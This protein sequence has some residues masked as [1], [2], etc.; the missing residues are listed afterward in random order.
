MSEPLLTWGGCRFFVSLQEHFTGVF[1]VCAGLVF[2]VLLNFFFLLWKGKN[3]KTV[4]LLSKNF[5]YS[6]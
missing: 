2:L 3:K 1:S 6:T 4:L 5:I